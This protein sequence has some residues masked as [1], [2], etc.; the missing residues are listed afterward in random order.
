[1]LSKLDWDLSAVIAPDY[2][3]HIMQRLL[4]LDLVLDQGMSLGWPNRTS[5]AP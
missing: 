1:M 4:K 5:L 3:E 2:V